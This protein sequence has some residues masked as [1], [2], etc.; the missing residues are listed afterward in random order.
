MLKFIKNNRSSIVN[1]LELQSAI[2]LNKYSLAYALELLKHTGFLALEKKEGDLTI[3]IMT[4]DRQD[5]S[6]LIEYT[7]FVSELKQIQK[8]RG[9]LMR[10]DILILEEMLK[11]N[12][13]FVGRYMPRHVSTVEGYK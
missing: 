6:D 7:L 3:E 5:F 12:G 4:P 10:E 9:F 8:F 2:G 13:V 11:K 1:E